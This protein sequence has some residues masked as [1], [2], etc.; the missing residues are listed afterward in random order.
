MES[1]CWRRSIKLSVNKTSG[2]NIEDPLHTHTH[3]HKY[4][5]VPLSARKTSII[6]TLQISSFSKKLIPCDPR[7][8]GLSSSSPLPLLIQCLLRNTH[9]CPLHVR[10]CVLA[11]ET[12]CS[13]RGFMIITF[14]DA[15]TESICIW[16][17]WQLT[18]R[19][20]V[21]NKSKTTTCDVPLGLPY[22]SENNTEC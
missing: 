1:A 12:T 15:E 17:K 9:A 21:K 14:S 16:A 11:A 10:T 8:T 7:R 13:Y 4:V 5:C 3:T 2:N 6:T 19:Q 22:L 20:N 18:S